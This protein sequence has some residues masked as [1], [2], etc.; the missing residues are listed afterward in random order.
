[1]KVSL[2][3]IKPYVKIDIPIDE[4]V[5][6][7]NK[8]LGGVE[9]VIHYSEKYRDVVIVNIVECSKHPNADRLSVC[10]VD[11]AGVV[12]DVERD[13]HGLVQVVCGAP[14]V[15]AGMLAAWLPP[16]ATVPAT[17]GTDEP[18][19]L[20]ARDLRG[21]KSNGMLAAGDELAIGSDH[22]GILELDADEWNPSGL[23]P[24]A[25]SRFADVYG[26]ND[27]VI[28]IENK[29]FTHRPDCFG[30]IGVAREIAGI[31]GT[32][33]HQPKWLDELPV[34]QQAAGLEL[35]VKNECP[36]LA[37]RLMAVAIKDVEMVASPLWLQ[38]E[39][40][41]VGSKPINGIVDVTNYIMMLTGQPT[42]AYDYDTI[43]GA[44][45]MTRMARQ[46]E[47]IT[48]I[49]GKTYQLTRDD[50]VVADAEKA[51]GLAGIMGGIDTEVTNTTKNII[52]EVAN[53]DMYAV[54]KSS[55][56]HGVFT[57][58]LTRFNKGQ[59]PLQNPYILS[60]LMSSI[61]DVAG[62]A[63]A[64]DVFDVAGELVQP[65]AISIT[66]S[67]INERLGLKLQAADIAETL[68]R[69]G[70]SVEGDETLTV[71]VPYWRTDLERKEDIV[72]EVGRLKGFDALPRTMPTRSMT[73][74]PKNAARELK[75]LIRRSLSR[76]GANEILSYSFVNERIMSQAGQNVADAYRIG[77]A[78]SPDLQY[79][80][81]SL[82]PSLLE[83]AVVNVRAGYDE[84]ALFEIGKS[85]QKGMLDDDALPLEQSLV[86]AV[87]T[88]K[89]EKDG[90]AYFKLRR[91]LDQLAH[92]LSLDLLYTPLKDKVDDPLFAPY[93]LDRSA[94]ISLSDGTSVGV[95]GEFR[96][97]VARAFKLPMYSAGFSLSIAPI[98]SLLSGRVDTSS[99]QSLSRYPSVIEDVSLKADA[100]VSYG[101]M[102][103]ALTIACEA[104]RDIDVTIE[105]IAIY[106]SEQ[107]TST[108]TT[109]YRL[110]MTSYETT[111]TDEAVRPLVESIVEAVRA[112]TGAEQV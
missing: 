47:T 102:T 1:M 79:Y 7:I 48:L 38:C 112:A 37:P 13:E 40:I 76:S 69:V 14:N 29:M 72:E 26:M 34:F 15:K 75:Q 36:E 81:L 35:T 6:R 86:E 32:E 83:K 44:T 55:M 77:N 90:A 57:D 10:L 101:D 100:T 111:L 43:A 89:H 41:R 110:T 12:A 8:Q 25:G 11:D 56:R 45:L 49:N 53:F 16:R 4:L 62:G 51:V 99:Y 74:A 103:R 109:T 87:Y 61:I 107:D 21:V 94:H 18:F 105:P 63:Q 52:L 9:E 96:T 91:L 64:S 95:I 19:V 2:E 88:S 31:I 28:D 78:L 30:Q 42:H 23:K 84:F 20:D 17:Y 3:T 58:A 27:T 5:E 98:Q 108:K 59:S 33:F 85:H 22:S 82:M 50:V 97:E 67:F 73:P 46:D 24:Q 60:L 65:S 71:N 39:L 66:P 104:S 70:M 68:E 106:Q 93:D 92:H 80:R 54:R